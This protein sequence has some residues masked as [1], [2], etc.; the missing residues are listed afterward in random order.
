MNEVSCIIICIVCFHL[1]ENG[2]IK[3]YSNIVL[4]IYI[5]T[6]LF[7]SGDFLCTLNCG[8]IWESGLGFEEMGEEPFMVY[9]FVY[10]HFFIVDL[11]Y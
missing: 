4:Y 7:M 5:H 6:L 2:G 11:C 3:V 1:Y 8:Y 9:P 10:K